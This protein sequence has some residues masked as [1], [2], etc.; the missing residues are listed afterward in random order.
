[1]KASIFFFSILLLASCAD[2]N[3]PKQIEEVE[4]IEL[5]LVDMGQQLNSISMDSIENIITATSII[6]NRIKE[7]YSGD[8]VSVSFG[9]KLESFHALNPELRN[10]VELMKEIDSAIIVRENQL[11]LLKN[12]INKSVG[13]RAK[14]DENIHFEKNEA[15]LIANFGIF[16]DSS[17]SSS[18]KTFNIL[19][20]E[21][22]QF[23]LKCENDFKKQQIP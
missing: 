17:S 22:E 4:R 18:L 11:S 3:R 2:L 5:K 10:I 15:E 8:T 23:S 7:Y 19:Q 9:E 21:I 12:E 6:D 16:C 20:F 14:Y 13:N 1:M